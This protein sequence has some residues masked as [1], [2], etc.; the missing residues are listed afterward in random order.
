MKK[1]L[2]LLLIPCFLGVIS[3][4]CDDDTSVPA[5][6]S[7]AGIDLCSAHPDGGHC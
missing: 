2:L 6:L 4:G 3:I 1:L 7:G 5:D